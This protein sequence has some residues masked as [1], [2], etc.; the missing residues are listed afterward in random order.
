MDYTPNTQLIED[1]SHNYE[2][3]ETCHFELGKILLVKILSQY[4]FEASKAAIYSC[5]KVKHYKKI[6]ILDYWEYFAN[7]FINRN[8]VKYYFPYMK[9][10]IW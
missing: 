10:L 4:S 7:I 1:V 3:N 6:A 5:N 8:K 9:D 2:D